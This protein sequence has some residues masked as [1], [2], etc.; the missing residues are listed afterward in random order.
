M[1]MWYYANNHQRQGPVSESEFNRLAAEGIIHADTLVWRQG[2]ANWQRYAE[3]APPPPLPSTLPPVMGATET[4]AANPATAS[5]PTS[6][7]ASTALAPRPLNYAGFWIRVPAALIDFF[8]LYVVDQIVAIAMHVESIDVMQLAQADYD[9]LMPALVQVME[10]MSQVFAVTA[11]LSL[12]FYWFFL[13]RFAATPGK[14]AL[15]LRVVR[16][17]GQPLTH[18]QIVLRFLAEKILSK[19]VTFGIGYVVC[20][21]DEEKRTLH[22]FIAG[23]RVVKKR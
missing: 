1:H 19:G 2:M 9:H 5:T 13:K 23:T 4:P 17:D 10:Q 15:G 14:L 3:V 12:A 16:P 20:A 8:I 11:T 7:F 6:T 22:D 21:F 18:G